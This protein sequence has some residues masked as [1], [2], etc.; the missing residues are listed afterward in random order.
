MY[1]LNPQCQQAGLLACLSEQIEIGQPDKIT[2]LLW[3][4]SV[5]MGSELLGTRD[6]P[7]GG[8][9]LPKE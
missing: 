1:G 9:L 6:F 4:V 2:F 5:E 8:I 3:G 7:V